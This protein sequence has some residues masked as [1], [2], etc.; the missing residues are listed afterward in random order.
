VK[1]VYKDSAPTQNK[2]GVFVVA[3]YWLDGRGSIPGTA[4][5]FVSTAQCPD[6]L[7]GPPISYA[8]RTGGSSQGL[9]WPV[10]EAYHLHLVPR[11]RLVELYLHSLMC[12]HDVVLN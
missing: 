6:R 10:R 8:M 11:S 12:L 4:K 1:T 7:W 2:R 3:G 9:K 5:S